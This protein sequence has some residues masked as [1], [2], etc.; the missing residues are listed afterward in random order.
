MGS[1]RPSAHERRAVRL[2]SRPPHGGSHVLHLV[3][4]A[5]K[6]AFGP[7]HTAE[8]EREH[9]EASR[10]ELDADGPQQWV[11]L[12]AAVLRMRVADHRRAQGVP[13]GGV[14]LPL[15]FESVFCL[16]RDALHGTRRMVAER[17]GTM[18]P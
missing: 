7:H 18:A 12:A 5:P 11:V 6:G 1:E 4:P 2:L 9:H 13:I 17:C 8:V 10:G 3:D 14:N 16:E 15:E